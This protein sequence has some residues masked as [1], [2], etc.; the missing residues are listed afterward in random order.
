MDLLPR[1]SIS[2]LLLAFSFRS[3]LVTLVDSL[4]DFDELYCSRVPLRYKVHREGRDFDEYRFNQA[5]CC[6]MNSVYESTH[7]CAL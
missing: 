2:G 4:E 1:H 5:K 3:D 6:F 7:Q